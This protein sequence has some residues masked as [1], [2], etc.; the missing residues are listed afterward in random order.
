MK[1]PSKIFLPVFLGVSVAFAAAATPGDIFSAHSEAIL[2]DPL[3]RVEGYVFATGFGEAVS[4]SRQAREAASEKASLQARANLVTGL[5]VE[6]LTWPEAIP[7]CHRAVLQAMLMRAIETQVTLKRVAEV[8]N[9]EIASGRWR[10]IVALPEAEAGNVPR[11][12]FEAARET[13]LSD[14]FILARNAP[15]EALLSLR[16]TQGAVPAPIERMAWEP[17]LAQATFDTPRLAALPRL[18]GRYPLVV[19]AKSDNADYARGQVCYG[20]GDLE[21]AY[22]AFLRAAEET[23]SFDALNMAGNVARR[24]GHDPEAVA[25]LLQAAY[26]NPASPYPWVH[27]AFVAEDDVLLSEACCA[28]AE[29]LGGK[30]AWVV[31]QIAALRANRRA[32]GTTEG[33]PKNAAMPTPAVPAKSAVPVKPVAPTKPTI[34]SEPVDPDALEPISERISR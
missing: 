27:L 3:V 29:A 24:L 34:P 19:T 26:L 1:T 8:S 21:G 25:L 33:A 7:A 22:A 20:R 9:E 28:R 31:G 2:A 18:A 17:L 4:A 10:A 32:T 23:L 16:K 14:R 11:L 6:T 13:L 5:S 30:D 12:T 15:L